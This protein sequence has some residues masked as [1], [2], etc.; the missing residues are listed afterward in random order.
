MELYKEILIKILENDN[1]QIS[2]KNLN[3][4]PT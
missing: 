4:N 2:F 1:L 3:L